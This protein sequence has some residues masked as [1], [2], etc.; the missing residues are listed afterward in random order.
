MQHHSIKE[1]AALLK[2]KK[3]LSE[4]ER[5]HLEEDQ[6]KGVK[7]L[8]DTWERK[9]AKEKALETQYERMLAFEE[10]LYTKG[11]SL[12][13]GMDEAGRGPL[14]GPVVAAAVIIDPKQPIIGV[15][16][17]KQLT[18]KLRRELLTEIKAKALGIG[19]GM[20]S[21]QEIDEVNIYQ[22]T[23]LAMKRAVEALTPVPHY[24]LVDAMTVPVHIPQHAIT[25]GD[26]RSVSIASA[27]IVAKETRDA[28]MDDLAVRYP[29][30][31][32]EDH[33]GYGTAEHLQAIKTLGPCSEHRMSFSPLRRED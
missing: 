12:V 11:Y 23:I 3:T 29:G 30:Y 21:A 27:S 16:D 14:A 4:A 7:S 33:H 25:K 10:Q 5:Q 9:R 8:L 17:S 31:G 20:A 15:N 18:K 1:I 24:L 22:A 32:F 19:V 2:D 6:R 26:A 28:L 13:A